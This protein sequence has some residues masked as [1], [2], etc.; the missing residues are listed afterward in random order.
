MEQEA[1]MQ[2]ESKVTTLIEP[3]LGFIREIKQAGGDTL[4]NCFQCATCSV[5]CALSPDEKPYPRVE[6]N[7]P[8]SCDK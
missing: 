8:F 2:V 6:E 3:D 1:A 5:V 4:K 7:P